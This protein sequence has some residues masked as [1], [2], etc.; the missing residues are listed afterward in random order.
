M[1][2]GCKISLVAMFSL[3]TYWNYRELIWN[4]AAADLKNR[5]K[6]SALGFLWSFMSPLLMSLVLIFVFMQ[7]FKFTIDNYPLYIISGIIPWRFFG[8]TA[9]TMHSVKLYSSLIRKIYFPRQVLVFS[10]CLSALISTSIEF[11]LLLLISIV[12]GG[13]ITAWILLVP[14]FLAAQFFLVLGISYVIAALFVF[15]RDL[16]HIWEVF[17]Q[18]AFYAAPII[19]PATLITQ[20]SP[21]YL[22]L[23]ANP[24]SHFIITYRHLFMYGDAPALGSIIGIAAFTVFAYVAGLLVFKKFEPRFAEEV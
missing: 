8:Y 15:Y 4:L 18:V 21:Y 7:V 22:V 14:V 2:G 1:G 12:L 3:R 20:S 10:A 5:Y 23:L 13:N 19:Y 9:N 24:M 11:V 17:L 6:N 16:Q